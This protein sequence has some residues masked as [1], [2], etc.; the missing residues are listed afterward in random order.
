MTIKQLGGVFGRNPTFNDVTIE[1]D[2]EIDGTLKFDGD[3]DINS[4]LKVNGDLEVLGQSALGATIPSDAHATWSQYFVGE[5][6]SVISE[7]LNAGGLFGMWL[8][9]NV[10]IDNDTGSFAYLTDDEASA[11]RCEAGEIEFRSAPLGNAGDPMTLTQYAKF[12]TAG[13]L[14]FVSGKGIDFSATAQAPGSTSELLADYEEGAWTAT[15]TDGANDATMGGG[16]VCQYTKVGRLVTVHGYIYTTSLGSVTG[17]LSISGL[18][19]SPLAGGTNYTASTAGFGDSLAITAG[20]S[21]ALR[22][23]PSSLSI[24]L[25]LWDAV[26]GSTAMQGTEWTSN[27]ELMFSASYLTA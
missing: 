15:I 3:I 14:A 2:L 1:G 21:V 17:S 25:F 12:T 5:K 27:G 23:T 13:N 26:T 4:D 6:G 24:G 7:K 9:D 10:Y 16:G 8:T 18:P 19:F 20:Q 22:F 11:V